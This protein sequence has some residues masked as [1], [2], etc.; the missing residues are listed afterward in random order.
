[1]Y[2]YGL[3]FHRNRLLAALLCLALCAPLALAGQ[4]AEHVAFAL[5]L[6]DGDHSVR[7]DRL[8]FD[9]FS[10]QEGE[11][12][13]AVDQDGQSLL[14]TRREGKLILTIASGKEITLPEIGLHGQHIIWDSADAVPGNVDIELR[15]ADPPEGLLIISSQPLDQAAQD[16]IRGAL[17]SAGIEQPVRFAP[18]LR[19]QVRV[20][21]RSGDGIAIEKK[22][23]R[24]HE[25]TDGSGK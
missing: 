2:S 12:R 23:T 11:S 6:E 19:R 16:R 17:A 22:I 18:H 25:I 7:L 10:L 8:D 5:E 21:E 9:P 14:F 3:D 24:E 4:Q 13:S 1:M 20:I 15:R